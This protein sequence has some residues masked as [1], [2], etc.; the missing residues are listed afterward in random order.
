MSRN[1]GKA[2]VLGGETGLLG[3]AL[4][5]ELERR[6]CEVELTPRPGEQDF[7]PGELGAF[8]DKAAPDTI[9]NTWAYTQVDKA[10]EEPDQAARLNSE[11][12]AV[13][14]QVASDRDFRLVHY[15]TDF[16]F[17]GDAST[18]Y[19]EADQ[20][21]PR[22]A[23]GRTKLSGEAA[24]LNTCPSTNLLIIR[25]AWLFGP[26]KKNFV[27]TI[28]GLAAER[29]RI[30]VVADQRGSPTY[31]PDLARYSVTLERT[32]TYGIFHVANS[33]D[34]SWFDLAALAVEA[35]GLDCEVA[36]ILSAEYPQKAERPAYSVL[37]TQKFE[38]VAGV[39]PR[40]WWE[41]VRDY[42]YD[43]ISER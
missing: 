1:R 16:V 33:G 12:P 13:L 39:A 17:P 4:A 32:G 34:A 11:L 25:T 19:T 21:G 2:L 8:I 42:V 7:D 6:G 18:P 36:P 23:Y 22:S 3:M 9:F 40:P 15:S 38:R 29:D 37:S 26:G 30:T 27:S 43:E 10:E 5:R 35:A 31:T 41:A 28:C 24:L 14:A 20:P